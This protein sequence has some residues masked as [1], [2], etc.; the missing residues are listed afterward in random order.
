MKHGGLS[1]SRSLNHSFRIALVARRI[2]TLSD[3]VSGLGLDL[4]T[5][6][7]GR[8]CLGLERTHQ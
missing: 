6:T 4:G 5:E 8:L 2:L 1:R 3:L 7:L